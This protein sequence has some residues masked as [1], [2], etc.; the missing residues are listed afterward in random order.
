MESENTF[1]SAIS[2]L[3]KGVNLVEASAGTGKTFAIAMLVLR[4]VVEKEIDLKNILI[5]TFTNAATRELRG[6]I[7]KRLVEA[8]DILEDAESGQ[9][10]ETFDQPLI[11]WADKFAGKETREDAIL[12]LKLAIYSIDEAPIFTIHSFCQR[13]LA[14]Q[15]LESNQPFDCELLSDI[16]Q[17]KKEIAQDFWRSL[18]Y[19]DCGSIEATLLCDKRFATPDALLA[20]VNQTAEHIKIEPSC[21]DFAAE[22]EAV[23][24][25]F[26]D[27]RR[28]WSDWRELFYKKLTEAEGQGYLKKDLAGGWRQWVDS[29]DKWCSA[30]NAPLFIHPEWLIKNEFLKQLNGTKLQGNK[31][32]E[33]VAD[34]LF[35]SGAEHLGKQLDTIFLHYRVQFA[36]ILKKEISLRLDRQGGMGFDGLINNLANALENEQN[37]QLQNILA[38]RFSAA[39]IDEFQDTD[40]KQY[41]IFS[42]L[43]GSGG[44]FLYLIGDPKQAIYGFR[45]ADILSY[46]VARESKGVR[47]LTLDTNYRSHPFLINE[48]NRLFSER[49]NP[50][51]YSAEK[52][53]FSPVKA[54]S[55]KECAELREADGTNANG[56]VYQLLPSDERK[57]DNRWGATDARALILQQTVAEIGRL[58]EAERYYIC[59]GEQQ[60]PLTPK[61]IAVLVRRNDTGEEYANALADMG[62]PAVVTSRTSVFS[63]VECGELLILLAAILAPNT[64]RRAK[65]ALALSWFGYDGGDI[66]EIGNDESRLGE[67]Q[68]R[69]A[70]YR[71]KWQNASFFSMITTLL[72]EEKALVCLARGMRGERRISNLR[73]LLVL[74]E[75]ETLARNLS[76]QEVYHWLVRQKSGLDGVEES[77]L[78]LESD[79]EAVQIVTMH[80]AKGLEYGVV[81]CVDLWGGSDTLA[82]EKNQLVYKEKEEL[83]LDLGSDAFDSHREEAKKER[84]AEELRLLYVAL[85]RA[86]MRCYTVWADVKG[87]KRK[88]IDSF[89]SALGYLLFPNM[90]EKTCDYSCQQQSISTRV[91]SDGVFMEI[92]AAEADMPEV[93]SFHISSE[94]NLQRRQRKRHNSGSFWR[95][96]SFSSLA[97]LSEYGYEITGEKVCE[98]QEKSKEIAVV[99][100]PAGARFGS[101]VHDIFENGSFAELAENSEQCLERCRESAAVYGIAADAEKL[102]ELVRQTLQ[103]PLKE[104]LE[105]GDSSDNFSLSQLTD[106]DCIKEMPFYLLHGA[107]K[108]DKI[109]GLLADDPAVVPLE[110]K[111]IEGYLT[112]FLDLICKWNGRYYI[113]DYKTNYLGNFLADYQ[114]DGLLAAMR[115][116][117]YGLQYWLYTVALH[118]YLRKMIEDYDYSM[119]FGGVFYLFVRGMMAGLP[120]SGVFFTVPPAEKVRALDTL[121]GGVQ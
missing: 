30:E 59:E 90:D 52:L 103:T 68:L 17:L 32:K 22:K 7:R 26:T 28:W 6:R 15:A 102:A 1:N 116:H 19:R 86:K 35:F 83:F 13:M 110:K 10:R 39:L 82:G 37:G 77:E 98:S 56:M 91:N 79:R 111:E 112:G 62:I 4:F 71:R 75:E 29:L 49:E 24:R 115:S 21:G 65:A 93:S 113:M 92:L 27:I 20:S 69:L 43:F 51:L 16:E 89:N 80:S 105:T 94:E 53:P 67:W 57:K 117:N 42:R 55:P 40:S 50:F 44:H 114:G 100:L 45:G 101:T 109:C 12:R 41:S 74:I 64:I 9:K 99:G 47:L 84:Q 88:T 60:Q 78:L 31:K 18:F 106:G 66:Y 97:G 25:L 70:E 81:F 120:G 54:R 96:S 119:H 23:L 11:D 58:L 72:R 2:S 63:S 46:F 36:E 118:R 34:L 121:L 14:E 104:L 108:T 61:D 107:V 5:V 38:K 8:R 33:F 73:Q 48:I 76:P 3:H 87:V 95:L 85:T